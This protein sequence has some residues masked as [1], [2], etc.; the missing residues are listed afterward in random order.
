MFMELQL[1]DYGLRNKP[2]QVLRVLEESTDMKKRKDGEQFVTKDSQM[3][4][5]VQ[6]AVVL[7]KDHNAL[8]GHNLKTSNILIFTIQTM[9][10]LIMFQF[11]FL[12]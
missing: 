2:F 8:H 11:S 4:L 7:E 1:E 3:I 5:A 12:I 9:L 10:I 6:F